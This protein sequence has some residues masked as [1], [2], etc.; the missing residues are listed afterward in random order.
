MEIMTEKLYEHCNKAWTKVISYLKIDGLALTNTKYSPIRFGQLY[1]RHL[2]ISQLHFKIQDET[3]IEVK[4]IS[5]QHGLIQ[6]AS[7]MNSI[8]HGILHGLVLKMS[9]ENCS[10]H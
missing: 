8:P 5:F 7:K 6:N 4:M 1:E 3:K 10:P 9:F 2:K